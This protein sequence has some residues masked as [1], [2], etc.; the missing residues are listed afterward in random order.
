MMYLQSHF[1]IQ[2]LEH[3]GLLDHV[4]HCFGII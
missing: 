3:F 2:L 4:F 1:A